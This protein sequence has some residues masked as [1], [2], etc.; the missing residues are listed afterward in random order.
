MHVYQMLRAHRKEMMTI[1]PVLY[2]NFVCEWCIQCF[3]LTYC[4]FHILSLILGFSIPQAEW[5][6]RFNWE[7]RLTLPEE[8]MVHILIIIY[9]YL[10]M[11]NR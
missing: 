3:T 4:N 2:L 6:K 10:F 11:G 5:L 1:Q 9:K 8:S 7:L